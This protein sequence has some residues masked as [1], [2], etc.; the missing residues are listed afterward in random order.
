M[1]RK[2]NSKTQPVP[3]LDLNAMLRL[4]SCSDFIV[5]YC[6]CVGQGGPERCPDT[7]AH[8]LLPLHPGCLLARPISSRWFAVLGR[9]RLGRCR[10]RFVKAGGTGTSIA[11]CIPSFPWRSCRCRA[12]DAATARCVRSAQPGQI[13]FAVRNGQPFVFGVAKPFPLAADQLEH[14]IVPIFAVRTVGGGRDRAG[15]RVG[16]DRQ[17]RSGQFGWAR[18]PRTDRTLRM[19]ALLVVRVGR[20][21]GQQHVGGGR[22]ELNRAKAM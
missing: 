18:C 3:S 1:P 19:L 14:R 17:E 6:L 8:L 5:T 4:G 16:T 21:I 15:D 22:I 20:W 9:S 11:C 7:F 10:R 12:D 2:Q 13:R